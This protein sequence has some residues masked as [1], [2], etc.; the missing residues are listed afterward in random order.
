MATKVRIR[1]ML[2]TFFINALHSNLIVTIDINLY[3]DAVEA[4]AGTSCPTLCHGSCW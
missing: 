2:Y 3:C 1:S 4:R